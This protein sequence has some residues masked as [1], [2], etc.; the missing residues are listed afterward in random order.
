[1]LE[2]AQLMTQN[3]LDLESLEKLS[4]FAHK[5]AGSAGFF[6]DGNFGRIA[7]KLD[8]GVRSGTVKIDDTKLKKLVSA[9][10]NTA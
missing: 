6:D 8:R 9:I 5:L 7:A 2:T 1:M 10:C 3:M 4:G